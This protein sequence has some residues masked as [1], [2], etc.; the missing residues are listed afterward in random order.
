[1]KLV[2]LQV[3]LPIHIDGTSFTSAITAARTAGVTSPLVQ[4]LQVRNWARRVYF[5]LAH[6]LVLP[7][8]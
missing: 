2:L 1:M 8:G 4:A 7:L 5:A 6:L 3:I